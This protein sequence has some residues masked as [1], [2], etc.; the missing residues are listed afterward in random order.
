M[1]YRKE[2]T[3][4]YTE[5]MMSM[6]GSDHVNQMCSPITL[7]DID[8]SLAVSNKSSSSKKKMWTKPMERKFLDLLLE[9]VH[10]GRKGEGGFK[11]EAWTAI[12]RTFNAAM[13]L[14]LSRDHFKNKLK[15]WKVGYK[16]MKD[17]KNTS[18]LAW[19]E[20]T[21]TVDAEDSVWDDLLKVG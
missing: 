20:E 15:T 17:L 2:Y 13:D 5:L 21:Q 18:G 3:M 7:S 14:N 12:E 10:L 16:V 6:D 11:K 9:Q 1:K 4:A 19:N 8:G